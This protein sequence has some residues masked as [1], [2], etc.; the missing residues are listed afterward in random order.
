MLQAFEAEGAVETGGAI[1]RHL[2]G[3]KQ[4]GAAATH[5]INQRLARLPASQFEDAGCEVFLQRR[6]HAGF[7]EA[8][9][10]QRLAGG[11]EIERAFVFAEEDVD[12]D[13]GVACIDVRAFA[14]VF[15]ETVTYGVFDA[16]G[17]EIQRF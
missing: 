12:A 8:A 5:R 4:E 13:I 2:D 16:Q 11:V 15:A 7:A 3:F 14:E 9:L 10:P 17:D 6:F 1:Q